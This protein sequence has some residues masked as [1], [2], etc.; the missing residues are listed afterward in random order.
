MLTP[1]AVTTHVYTQPSFAECNAHTNIRVQCCFEIVYSFKKICQMLDCGN[2]CL[3][4]V[5]EV[6]PALRAAGVPYFA[7][8]VQVNEFYRVLFFQKA[9]HYLGGRCTEMLH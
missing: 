7:L 5:F 1:P 6:L 4:S 8:C 2:H 9:E 3:V